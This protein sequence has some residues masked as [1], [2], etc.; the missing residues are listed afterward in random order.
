MQQAFNNIQTMFM[1]K[2]L[3]F[4]IYSFYEFKEEKSL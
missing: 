1:N 3:Y 4:H 2:S